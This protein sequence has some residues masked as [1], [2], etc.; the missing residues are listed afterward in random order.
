MKKSVGVRTMAALASSLVCAA[1]IAAC[2]SGDDVAVTHHVAAPTDASI[3]DG[4]VNPTD[5]PPRVAICAKYGSYAGVQALVTKAMGV[6]AADCRIGPYFADTT[7]TAH[8]TEC[9]QKYMGAAFECPGV[10]YDKDSA[11]V[12]CQDL[13]K[14]HAQLKLSGG[15]YD[16]FLS[17]FVQVM[18][19]AK[20]EQDDI[21]QVVGG[22][23]GVQ[24]IANAKGGT[25]Q[26]TCMPDSK[27][28][29]IDAGPDARDGSKDG[30]SD[31]PSTVDA[32]D[33]GS[34]TGADDA[35]DSG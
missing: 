33:S 28:G 19:A 35:S 21:N 16:A 1:A 32:A 12:A 15:D 22:L 24:G 2:S 17:D 30:T 5:M 20:F 3:S 29:Y 7:K 27:C 13:R 9:L 25:T 14:A 31:A 11:G 6:F 8:H 34:D 23:N 10:V 18:T 4:T 26:C